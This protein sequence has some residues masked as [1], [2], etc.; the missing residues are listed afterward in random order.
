MTVEHFRRA[1]KKG[2]ARA[3]LN[4]AH[5]YALGA[6]VAQDGPRACRLY[7]AAARAGRP[8]AMHAL[9]RAHSAGSL[10]LQK[11][12]LEAGRWFHRAAGRGF[13]LGEGERALADLASF[14]ALP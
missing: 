9:G 3:T 5:C 2:N 11:S 8:E 1:A 4:L 10:G 7:R 12:A 13:P 6:G 14:A